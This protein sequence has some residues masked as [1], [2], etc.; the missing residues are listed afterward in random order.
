MTR[1]SA[2]LIATRSIGLRLIVVML[3]GVAA[4]ATIYADSYTVTMTNGTSFETRYKPVPAEG[5]DNI[6][7][8]N[9]DRGNWIG[10]RVDEIADIASHAESTGF[11]YQLNTTTLF[12]GWMPNDVDNGEEGADDGA[13]GGGRDGGQHVDERF[14]EPA[15]S[16]VL[17][18]FVDI[19]GAEGGALGSQASDSVYGN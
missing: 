6:V 8:L 15:P 19:P 11:G 10:L 13:D 9:T 3:L 17:E 7:L 12:V 14:P 18:Q 4:T 16:G 2:R 5:D 1:Y